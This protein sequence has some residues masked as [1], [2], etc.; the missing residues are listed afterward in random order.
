MYKQRMLAVAGAS[1][2]KTNI[3]FERRMVSRNIFFALLPFIV[4][5]TN[6]AICAGLL[7]SILPQAAPYNYKRWA[8]V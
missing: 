7:L 6:P 8:S 3:Y 2:L 5:T 1:L 4:N